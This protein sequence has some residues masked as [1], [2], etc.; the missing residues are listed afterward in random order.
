MN[1][2]EHIEKKPKYLYFL[3]GKKI[4]TDSSSL[5]G[6]DVRAKLPPEQNGY[7]IYLETVGDE[8]DELVNDARTFSLEN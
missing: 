4:E 6:A 7:A 2:D 1:T 8:P 3:D 5:T